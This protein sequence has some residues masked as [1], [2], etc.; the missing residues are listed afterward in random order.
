M[1]C[2]L[3]EQDSPPQ[4]LRLDIAPAVGI[5]HECGIGVCRAHSAKAAPAGAPLLCLPCAAI[6]SN[7]TTMPRVAMSMPERTSR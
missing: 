6:R 7:V 2:Y 1:N 3:C 4:A 5:C